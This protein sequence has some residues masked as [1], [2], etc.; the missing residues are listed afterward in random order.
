MTRGFSEAGYQWKGNLA[1][2]TE[3]MVVN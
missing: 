3:M 2:V 1:Q